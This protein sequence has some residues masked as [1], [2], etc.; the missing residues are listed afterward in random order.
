MSPSEGD[1][2]VVAGAAGGVGSIA[3]QL[4]RNAGATVIGL[5]GEANHRWLADRG[6]IPVTYGEGVADR[7]RAASSG[8]VDAFID[9]FGDGYV[10]LALELGVRP[11]RINTIINFPA[12]Q[13][14]GVKTEGNA[15][16][17]SPEVLTELARTAPAVAQAAPRRGA[18]SRTASEAANTD[19]AVPMLP[20]MCHAH[21]APRMSATVS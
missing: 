4:A 9:A 11:E 21:Q 2:V 14:Y 19:T 13:K 10:E 15:K 8:Q 16:A 3:V 7:I 6:V 1:T 12:A 17:D 5:A 18:S 20:K